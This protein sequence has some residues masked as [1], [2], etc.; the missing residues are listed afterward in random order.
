MTDGDQVSLEQLETLLPWYAS[1]K[2]APEDVLQIEQALASVPELR[3][4]FELI[5]EERDAAVILNESLGAPS[6]QAIEKLFARLDTATTKAPINEHKAVQSWL[7]A[8]F[9]AQRPPWLVWMGMA[10][11]VV[12]IVEAGLLAIM[13]LGVAEKGTTY[14]TVSVA[15]KTTEQD[16]AFL[17]IAFMPDAT[18]AQIRHFLETHNASI[19][20]GPIAG[21]IFR[22]RVGDK[23]LAPKELGAIIAFLR[24]EGTIVRFVAPTT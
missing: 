4:R 9:S 7:A 22:I 21:D 2:L 23:A 3:R 6:L 1:G 18:A 12:A 24:N 14:W 15:K 13:F 20:E 19:V 17:L 8:R 16:S 11:A 5:L 10:A